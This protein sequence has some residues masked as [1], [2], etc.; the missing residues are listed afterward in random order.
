MMLVL[1][2]MVLLLGLGSSLLFDGESGSDAETPTGSP[3]T[4]TTDGASDTA[5]VE[6]REYPDEWYRDDLE[7][8]NLV[9]VEV[10]EVI[11]GD[12]LDVAAGGTT[13]RVRAYGFDTPERGER[14]YYEALDRLEELV[15]SRMLLLADER[16]EDP[17]GRQLR[18]LYTPDG[19][20]IDAVMV[21]EG[22]AEAWRA[23]GSL[24]TML[25]AIESDARDAEGGCLWAD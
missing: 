7:S 18:Y 14:C 15:G 2:A 12:T 19:L 9:P 13:L 20:L 10:L 16:L 3:A 24:R 17:G 5:T 1:G 22:Y 23:D 11:D 4:P 8:P 21:A 6:A 25:G